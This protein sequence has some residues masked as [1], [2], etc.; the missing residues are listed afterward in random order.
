MKKYLPVF[1]LSAF[2]ISACDDTDAP[3]TLEKPE[4]ST[5]TKV[6]PAPMEATS[7]S[8]ESMPTTDAATE[9]ESTHIQTVASEKA[10]LSGEQ[11]YQKSCINC[12]KS[13]AANAPKLGDSSAWQPRIAKGKDVLYQSAKQGIA[14]TA[15]M[16]KGTCSACSDEELEAAVDYMIDNSK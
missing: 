16:A 13:G 9:K 6:E 11:V 2:L 3:G 7:A 5:T 12:H 15:M 4:A 8:T 14:G 1:L 10:Q